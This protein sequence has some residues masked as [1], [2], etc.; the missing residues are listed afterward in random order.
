MPKPR[1]PSKVSSH[2]QLQKVPITHSHLSSVHPPS[3]P[4]TLLPCEL[5]HIIL[6]DLFTFDLKDGTATIHNVLQTCHSW[7]NM[8]MDMGFH[9]EVCGNTYLFRWAS[10][11]GFYAVEKNAMGLGHRSRGGLG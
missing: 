10:D 2:P 11:L 5:L 4:I 6:Q 8:A 9:G 7:R 3:S 1:K